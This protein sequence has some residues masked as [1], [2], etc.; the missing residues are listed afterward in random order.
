MKSTARR[1]LVL[2]TVILVTG[3]L[4]MAYS[5][6]QRMRMTPEQRAKE[7]KEQLSLTDEQVTKVTKIFESSQ[8]EMQAK[9]GD[10]QGDRDA[11]RQ[12]FQKSQA[13]NDSLIKAL[14]TEDQVKKYE[15]I[16]KERMQ[17]MQQ[18]MRNN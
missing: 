13:K 9:M 12:F 3:L 5:Q 14:L 11:M 1:L 15:E 7:L 6:G 17:R 2:A 18:R 8:K 16:Q 4:Q 10:L